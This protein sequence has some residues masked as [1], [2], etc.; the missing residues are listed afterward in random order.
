MAVLFCGSKKIKKFQKRVK[1]I[2]IVPIYITSKSITYCFE[3]EVV[4]EDVIPRSRETIQY[5]IIGME[6]NVYSRRN[7]YD[8]TTQHDSVKR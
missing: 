7:Y 6:A 8:S 5:F 2:G 3:T 1:Y 4:Q